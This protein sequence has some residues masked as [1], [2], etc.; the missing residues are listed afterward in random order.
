MMAFF[1]LQ[2][3][4]FLYALNFSTTTEQ[5]LLTM[6]DANLR[7]IWATIAKRSINN[8]TYN[9]L[10]DIIP[11][12][13]AFWAVAKSGREI[14]EQTKKS[15]VH[16]VQDILSYFLNDNSLVQDGGV[17]NEQIEMVKSVI[18]TFVSTFA[19]PW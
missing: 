11:L 17:N 10:S 9:G 1:D 12:I 19:F 15:G 18:N 13:A 6:Q 8:I 5:L 2:I 14:D 7:G 3:T 4:L 16:F